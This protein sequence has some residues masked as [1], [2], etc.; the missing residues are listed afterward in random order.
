MPEVWDDQQIAAARQAEFA[1]LGPNAD[2]RIDALG[3]FWKATLGEADG[4]AEMSRLLTAADVVRS[5]KK[6][7][8]FASQPEPP[9][10]DP[11]ASGKVTEEQWAK[12]SHAERFDYARSHD[13]SQIQKA[14]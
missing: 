11:A 6:M 2:A 4:A 5:E 10:A 13:Q 7:A 12:M 3:R 8:R 1:K 9:P 14:G